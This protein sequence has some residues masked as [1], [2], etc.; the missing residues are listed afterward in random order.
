MTKAIDLPIQKLQ[1][2]VTAPYTC[3]YL[4]RKMAQSL[5]AT[6][7]QLVDKPV[8]DHLIRQGFRRSGKYVYR[9]HC[10]QCKACVPVRLVLDDFIPSR[11]QKRVYKQH[12]DLSATVMPAHFD[13]SHFQLYKQYQS[14]RH[15]DSIDPNTEVIDERE[16]YQKFLCSSHVDSKIVTFHNAQGVLK[17][18][19]VIDML[20]DGAS[21]VYTFYDAEETKASYGTYTVLWLAKW[22]QKQALPYL[23][24]GYWIAESQ[25]MTYKSRFQPQEKL[26]HDKWV[27]GAKP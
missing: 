4:P 12:A 23:Y 14:L 1:F 25:K 20:E 21:A 11:N 22:L 7:H 3:S 15:N 16:Q 19:S 2:Y 26:I 6:P 27:Q 9:P 18:V 5:I 17:I 13:E 8:Y 24:L 10:E